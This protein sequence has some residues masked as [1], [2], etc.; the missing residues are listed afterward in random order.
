MQ[1]TGTEA[2]VLLTAVPERKMTEPKNPEQ[3]PKPFYSL[4]VQ[5]PDGDKKNIQ[6]FSGWDGEFTPSQQRVANMTAG[7]RWTLLVQE[8]GNY[9]NVID[10]VRQMSEATPKTIAIAE[11][12]TTTRERRDMENQT[13]IQAEWAIKAALHFLEIKTQEK[14]NYINRIQEPMNVEEAKKMLRESYDLKPVTKLADS[15]FEWVNQKVA[16]SDP[17]QV[18]EPPEE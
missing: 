5:M 14:I 10:V 16:G 12:A 4:P 8:R 2:T 15:M 9:T 3:Q 6:M 17:D 11:A 1:Q 18:F 13:R 7:E